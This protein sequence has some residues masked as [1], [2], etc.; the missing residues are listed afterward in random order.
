MDKTVSCLGPLLQ[1]PSVNPHATLLT[2]FM[3]A[4]LETYREL[5]AVDTVAR[6][7][8]ERAATGKLEHYQSV[9]R[10]VTKLEVFRPMIYVA[11]QQVLDHESLFER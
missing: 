1:K 5:R 8:Y 2:S 11:F 4:T 7:G 6:K 10:L 9:M 3:S